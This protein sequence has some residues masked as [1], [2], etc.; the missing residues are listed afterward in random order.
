[1]I[2][3]FLVS[4]MQKQSRQEVV[5]IILREIGFSYNLAWFENRRC[6]QL[7][8]EK[9]LSVQYIVLKHFLIAAEEEK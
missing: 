5:P 1:M 7:V 6:H 3:P 9:N 2:P 4:L 8:S